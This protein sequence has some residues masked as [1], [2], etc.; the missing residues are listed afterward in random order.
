MNNITNKYRIV[1]FLLIV[2]GTDRA[3][4]DTAKTKPIFGHPGDETPCECA[5]FLRSRQK[6]ET[7]SGHVNQ[8]DCW[9]V[10]HHNSISI[11]NPDDID[12]GIGYSDMMCAV[13]RGQVQVLIHAIPENENMTLDAGK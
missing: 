12:F 6:H 5:A 10:V 13:N 7:Y 11:G 4:A 3:I 8:R 9:E 1:L 2:V